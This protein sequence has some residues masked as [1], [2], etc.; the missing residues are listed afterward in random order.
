MS[1]FHWESNRSHEVFGARS[2]ADPSTL[3]QDERER[4][5]TL[6]EADEE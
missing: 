6:N 3:V 1:Q 2:V 4:M 5:N